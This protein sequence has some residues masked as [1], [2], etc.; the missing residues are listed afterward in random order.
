M[1][2]NI[3]KGTFKGADKDTAIGKLKVQ[4]REPLNVQL[5]IR[6]KFGRSYR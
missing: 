2:K 1:A 5:S 3:G 4:L 6:K